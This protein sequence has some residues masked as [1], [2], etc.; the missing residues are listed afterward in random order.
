LRHRCPIFNKYVICASG[1]QADIKIQL[2]KLVESQ[3]DKMSRNILGTTNSNDHAPPMSSSQP[4]KQK[5]AKVFS[6]DAGYNEKIASIDTT[7]E[8]KMSSW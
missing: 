7:D 3:G 6:A 5:S 4:K 8:S 1:F 2:R